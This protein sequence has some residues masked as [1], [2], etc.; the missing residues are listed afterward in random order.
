MAIEQ[1]LVLQIQQH[2]GSPPI[3]IGGFLAQLP[4]DY[5]ASRV[6]P[7]YTYKFIGV[8]S[9][10]TLNGPSGQ[11]EGLLEI[12][13][14][15]ADPGSLLSLAKAILAALNGF[16]GLLPDSDSTFLDKC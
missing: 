8:H 7:A 2:L 13:C 15:S 12:N 16:R 14:F 4:K 1:G 5:I 10:Q 11:F 6:G 9:I 3:A